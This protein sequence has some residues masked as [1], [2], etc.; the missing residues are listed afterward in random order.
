[1]GKRI[2]TDVILVC[3]H[4]AVGQQQAGATFIPLKCWLIIDCR[5][6][7]QRQLCAI[8]IYMSFCPSIILVDREQNEVIVFAP[9]ILIYHLPLSPDLFPIVICPFKSPEFFITFRENL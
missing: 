2:T 7:V 4:H 1:M 5:A 8:S 9:R 6:E 3:N